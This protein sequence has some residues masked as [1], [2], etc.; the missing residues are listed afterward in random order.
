M[1]EQ[2]VAAGSL[3][4]GP[5]LAAFTAVPRHL[6]LRRF[7]RQ[8]GDLSGWEAVSDTDPGALEM[9]YDGAT[10]VTQLDNDPHRWQNARG[11]DKPTPGTPTSSST[12]PGLMALMLEALDVHDGH[13]VLEIGTGSGYNAALL[14]HRLGSTLV[15]TVEV[16]PAVAD[17]ARASLHAAGYTPTVAVADGSA[18]HPEG[19]PYDRL[20][21]TCSASTVPPAWIDQVRPGG[22]ILTSLYRDLGGGPLVL[23]H[24]VG[25]GQAQGRFL[26]E[27][28]GFMPLRLHPPADTGPLLDAALAGT[29]P[30]ARPTSLG[31][32]LLDS[33]DFG[34]VAALRLPGV[35]SIGFAPDDSGPQRWLLAADGSWACLD[36]TTLTVSQHGTRRLWD[37]I[38]DIHLQWTQLGEPSRDRLGV[39]V[40]ATGEHRFW[41]DTPDGAWWSH[42]AETATT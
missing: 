24:V 23:L 33:A 17:S 4:S 30:P 39:T 21:A 11:A 38:E 37:E 36:E 20:I 31:A 35:A 26:P 27:Y 13:R 19:S 16:D 6:F 18:G 12:A 34:M 42:P 10:W 8:S 5:W 32:D 14:S 41:L 3:R 22:M 29:T 1:V 15:T 9:I 28:G 7:F 2:M 25:N 40:T